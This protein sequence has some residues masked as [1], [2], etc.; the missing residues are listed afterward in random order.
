M[1]FHAGVLHI[2]TNRGEQHVGLTLVCQRFRGMPEAW[3]MCFPILNS[4]GDVNHESTSFSEK[5]V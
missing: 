5:D 3:R 4:G 2:A 1:I